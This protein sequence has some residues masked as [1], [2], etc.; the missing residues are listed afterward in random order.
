MRCLVDQF[1]VLRCSLRCVV[2]PLP[3]FAV[4]QFFAVFSRTSYRYVIEFSDSI[5]TSLLNIHFIDESVYAA[6]EIKVTVEKKIVGSTGDF[7]AA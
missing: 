2:S 6:T 7:F 3:S 4:F 1:E 5:S